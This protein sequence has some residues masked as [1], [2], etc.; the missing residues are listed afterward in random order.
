MSS[1]GRDFPLLYFDILPRWMYRMPVPTGYSLAAVVHAW[2]VR[3]NLLAHGFYYVQRGRYHLEVHAPF[4]FPAAALDDLPNEP[5]LAV[6]PRPI[7][8]PHPSKDLFRR[9]G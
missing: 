5:F 1:A 7:V 2:L 9:F 3:N 8:I 4:P 6:S